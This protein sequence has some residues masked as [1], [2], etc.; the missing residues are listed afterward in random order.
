MQSEL[1]HAYFI[2]G[3]LLEAIQYNYMQQQ[4]KFSFIPLSLSWVAASLPKKSDIMF[5]LFHENGEV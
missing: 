3:R 2:R 1:E 5:F 4:Q